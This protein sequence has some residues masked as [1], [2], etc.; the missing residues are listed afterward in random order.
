[1]AEADPS[2]CYPPVNFIGDG[3]GGAPDHFQVQH[4]FRRA[5]PVDRVEQQRQRARLPLPRQRREPRRVADQA[6]RRVEN[7]A[8]LTVKTP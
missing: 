4:A 3:S 2:T 1:M 7:P 5:D 8:L 6:R